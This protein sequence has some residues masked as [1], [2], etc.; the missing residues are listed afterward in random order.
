M[1]PPFLDV[2]LDEGMGTLTF[3]N[4][5]VTIEAPLRI[6]D[7][8]ITVASATLT[9]PHDNTVVL[10]ITNVEVPTPIAEFFFEWNPMT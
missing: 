9:T 8:S 1:G 6:E 4:G 2:N 3:D 5:A 10:G 7:E